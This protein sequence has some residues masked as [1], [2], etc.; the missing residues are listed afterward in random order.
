MLVIMQ[1][2]AARYDLKCSLCATRHGACI[3]C[4]AGRCCVTAFHPLCARLAGLPMQQV[5]TNDIAATEVATS[6]LKRVNNA[7][8]GNA[9]KTG[10][11]RSKKNGGSRDAWA[12]EGCELSGGL[13]LLAFCGKHRACAVGHAQGAA[14]VPAK[15]RFHQSCQTVFKFNFFQ[16]YV[17][18][19]VGS[20]CWRS[21]C[22]GRVLTVHQCFDFAEI[23]VELINK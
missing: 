6:G 11:G 14:H 17:S 2:P 10:G 1:V 5:D 7:R 22:I 4:C 9:K 21:V 18:C 23:S 16:I 12:S 15:V 8:N 3:Q 20:D 19:Q 13:R